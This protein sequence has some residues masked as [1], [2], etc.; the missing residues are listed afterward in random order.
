MSNTRRTH[1]VPFGPLTPSELPSRQS[2]PDTWQDSV[3]IHGWGN[4]NVVPIQN[5]A[6]CIRFRPLAIRPTHTRTPSPLLLPWSGQHWTNDD[7]GS[8]SSSDSGWADS[9]RPP[10]SRWAD[11]DRLPGILWDAT[12]EDRPA[13]L[14]SDMAER[15]EEEQESRQPLRRYF[16]LPR[17]FAAETALPPSTPPTP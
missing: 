10:D 3:A 12:P 6:P 16:P 13:Q 14:D 7:E 5:V 2:T 8:I 9:D 1:T 15:V 4:T 11:T 17:P